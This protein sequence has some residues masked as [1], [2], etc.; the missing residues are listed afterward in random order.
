MYKLYA[1]NKIKGW[2][3]IKTSNNEDELELL[4]EKLE[5][6]DYYEYM[7]IENSEKGDRIVRR[8]ELYQ[9]CEA[10]RVNNFKKKYKVE[11][12]V[13]KKS[14]MKKKEELRKMTEDYIDR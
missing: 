14:K 13:V 4:S 10:V 11:T 8:Q 9:E 5:P 6:I 2:Q 12:K 3:L 7:I 1:Q